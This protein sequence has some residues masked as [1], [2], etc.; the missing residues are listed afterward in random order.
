MTN[1]QIFYAKNLIKIGVGIIATIFGIKNVM[2]GCYI[3][4]VCDLGN[5]LETKFRNNLDE[6]IF[7]QVS[8]VMAK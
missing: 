6:E 7:E 5:G 2:D 1:N 3:K 4:G 8:D